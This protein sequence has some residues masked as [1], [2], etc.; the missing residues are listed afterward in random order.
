MKH[1]TIATPFYAPPD[2]AKPNLAVEPVTPA[3]TQNAAPL[4][5]EPADNRS[6]IERLFEAVHF[7]PADNMRVNL[8]QGRNGQ[9]DTESV[10]LAS[11]LVTLTGGFVAVPGSIYGRRSK[12]SDK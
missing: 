9:P 8:T 2:K 12:G 11:V 3:P 1:S 7:E 6:R 10:K 4:T 5:A